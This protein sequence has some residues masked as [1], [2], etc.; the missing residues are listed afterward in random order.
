M[1]NLFLS[2]LIAIFLLEL[3]NPAFDGFAQGNNVTFL[4]NLNQYP[5]AGYNDIWGYV[6]GSGNE[7]ALLG[8][9]SGTSI[10]NVTDP[11]NP[12]EVAF[13]PGTFSTW[14]DIKTWGTY[15]YVVSDFTSDGLQIIDLSQLPT[16]ATLVNQITTWFESSHNIFIADGFAYAV[17]TEG[18]GG[19]HIIDLS[20][21]VNPTQTAYY[22]NG[23]Y[24]HDVFVWDDTVVSCN[25]SS[26]LYELL[27]VTNKSNPQ[28]VSSSPVLP[29]IYAH[30]GWMTED[31]RYFV[32]CE[33][34]NVRDI[35]VWDLQDRTTWNL[36]VSSWEMS[37]NSIVH[38]LF[39]RGNYAHI[40]Y[41]TSGYVVLDITDPTNPQ[42]AGQYDTYPQN[43][44]GNYDGAWGCY[45]YLASGNVLISDMSTGLYVLHFD[46]EVPVE[47]T[48]FSA[49]A[50]G[51]SVKLDWQTATETNNQGFEIQR[52]SENEF[53][54][55]GF[56]Q[57]NGTTTEP[58][59]YSY[60]DKNLS[61]GTYEY[62]LKQ[63]DFDGRFDYSDVVETE[64]FSVT[65]LELKQNY[66]NPFN[67]STKIKFSVP[68]NEFVNLSVYNLLGEKV[69]E[70]VNETKAAGEYEV[71]F[72]A[73]NL[74]SGIYVAK[75]S[76]GEYNQSIKMSLLK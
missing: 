16:T 63:I 11:E 61:N 38:N 1:K 33:E 55:V 39:V 27:N 58:R 7:Y 70:L 17:G 5:G 8:V 14:R 74:P 12:V 49:N 25:G 42:L 46:G 60:I 56:V 53:I 41:Y 20:N 47:L 62:R 29:G 50:T 19:I 26:E 43:N 36:E 15:A 45:P 34:F 13:I 59:Q 75:I 40:S 52:K 69:A 51:N 3:N 4:S 73:A 64:V 18:G 65:T 2:F 6:D 22:V 48:S 44:S 35:T 10:I 9:R 23:G 72:N 71:D 24:V 31:K 66:P 37:N 21:P 57:G 54:T 67:P 28:L 76:S 32:G 30:S 68:E